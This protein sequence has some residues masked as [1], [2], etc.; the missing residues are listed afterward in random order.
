[1]SSTVTIFEQIRSL[2]EEAEKLERI[3]CLDLRNEQASEKENIKQA[4]RVHG[5][6][7]Q[8]Q[9]ID[10]QLLKLYEDKEGIIKLEEESMKGE[11][12]NL[13]GR[14]YSRLNDIV[15]YNKKYADEVIDPEEMT[16]HVNE[17]QP[18][19]VQFSGEECNGIH[20]DLHDVYTLYLNLP[21]FAEKKDYISF[22]Q[23]FPSLLKEL[24]RKDKESKYFD[25]VSQLLQYL[26]NFLHRTQPLLNLKPILSTVEERFEKLWKQRRVPGWE[27][28][29]ENELFC[30]ACDK[31]FAKKTVYDAH[32]N[33]NKHKKA[34]K[35]FEKNL[36]V[37]KEVAL[38]E[39]KT[40][41]LCDVLND[42]I[43]ATIQFVEAKQSRSITEIMADIDALEEASGSESESES[44]EEA[45]IYNPKD[46][47][48]D[49]DGKPIPYWL[50]KLHGLNFYFEC[51][52]CGG[53]K[54]R[55]RR[56]FERH[57]MEWKHAQG[58][59]AL[60]IPNTKHFKEITK[61]DDA[62]KLYAKLLKETE[63][64]EFN[65]DHDE[66]YEDAEGNVYCKK[67][68]EDLKRQDLI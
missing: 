34:Q 32:L 3:A 66:E 56:N 46:L 53:E 4:H 21:Q 61:I 11:G 37:W 30:V 51:E 22:L 15:E 5:V 49:W 43:Y 29:P 58:M 13:F 12:E 47:P 28:T 8:V 1:M 9:S 57:F 10:E 38:R 7:E 50:Y 25:F 44:D 62:K 23:E 42:Q 18:L 17:D 33:G 27:L 31:Q 64:K 39:L 45:P 54:Y 63:A 40:L 2:H 20:L 35:A 48:L 52:I 65:A 6:M 36:G 19:P 68:Y 59:R 67:T 60:G 41:R 14:F 26:Q 55:G 16:L 24:P